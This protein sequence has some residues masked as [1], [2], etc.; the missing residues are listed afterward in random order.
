MSSVEIYI[1]FLVGNI[2]FFIKWQIQKV[3]VLLLSFTYLYNYTVMYS[4][5]ILVI[6]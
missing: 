1:S 3:H 6:S 5:F 2:H 4:V